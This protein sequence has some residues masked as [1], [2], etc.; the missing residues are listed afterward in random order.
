MSQTQPVEPTPAH[1]GIDPDAGKRTLLVMGLLLELL[2]SALAL[3]PAAAIVLYFAGRIRSAWAWTLLILAAVM[4]F[5]YV[6]LLAL[7][8]VRC[9]L[10]RPKEGL[11]EQRPGGLPGRPIL[12]FMLNL[13][14]LKARFDPPWA[15]MFSSVLSRVWP[16]GPLFDRFF[17]PRTTSETMGDTMYC[18]DPTMVEAGRH[19]EFG[20]QCVI[21]AHHFDNRGLYI[22]RVK[23]GD[24]AVIGGQATLMAGVEIGHHAV[25]AAHAVVMPDTRVPP[26]ELWGGAPA[27]K[28]KDLPAARPADA[29]GPASSIQPGPIRGAAPE[30]EA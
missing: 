4:V 9:L 5:N 20:F 10:P 7:L 27:R 24:H 6:Y 28:I 25:V 17:G 26:Y 19:V 12:L 21:L 15:A 18:L 16:L 1:G 11:H 13:L 3:W 29:G 22:R 14:L 30:G 2:L 8:A 23:I